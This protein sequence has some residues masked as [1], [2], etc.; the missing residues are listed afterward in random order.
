MNIDSVVLSFEVFTPKWE[1][2]N[3]QMQAS[4]ANTTDICMG[5]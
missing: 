3:K 2:E 1:R 5:R 4:I